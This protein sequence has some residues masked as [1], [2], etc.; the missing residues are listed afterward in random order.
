V[1]VSPDG[2]DGTG[3]SLVISRAFI[4]VADAA[5]VPLSTLNQPSVTVTM[6]V[7]SKNWLAG[8][9]PRSRI[10]WGCGELHPAALPHHRTCGFP[11][12]AVEQGG[13]QFP[14]AAKSHGMVNPYLL[15]VLVFNA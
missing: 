13:S 8:N 1:A 10:G 11:H 14:D 4:F 9:A 15:S 7:I 12:P 3:M 6:F 5:D 2:A